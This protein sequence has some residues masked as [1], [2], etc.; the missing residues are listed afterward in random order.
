MQSR[1]DLLMPRLSSENVLDTES[2][3]ESLGCFL[4]VTSCQKFIKKFFVQVVQS[5]EFLGLSLEKL[6][7]LVSEDELDVTSEEV[8]FKVNIDCCNSR[9][10]VSCELASEKYVLINV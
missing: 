8:V 5:E 3:A 9:S 4:L 7:A 1:P 2:F 10:K 6:S